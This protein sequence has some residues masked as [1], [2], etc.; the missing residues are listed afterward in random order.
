MTFRS[1]Y[2]LEQRKLLDCPIV[3]RGLR[4]LGP[5]SSCAPEPASPSWPTGE[6]ARRGGLRKASPRGCP[7][8][9]GDFGDE[10]TY[11]R[12]AD[13]IK[14]QPDAGLLPRGAAV[15][16]RSGD[17]GPARRRAHRELAR[18]RREAVRSRH[19]VRARAG[20]R[21]APVHRR[22]A[23]VPDRPL[24]R[25][26]GPHRA[27]VP[28]LL[29]HDARAGVEPEPH[30]VG[31]DHDGRDRRLRGPRQLL[32]AGR[33]PARRRRQP[34][35]ADGR[36]DRDGGA[37]A[38]RPQDDQGRDGARRSTPS[39][40]RARPHYV[41]GQ[42]D[43]YRSIK[44]VSPDSTTETFAALRL[45]IDNW[46]WAGVPF[47]I[48]TGKKMPVR[49][50]ELRLVFKQPPNLRLRVRLPPTRAQPARGPRRPAHRVSGCA[51]TR[52]APTRPAS[53]RSC[54]T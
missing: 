29:Q 26:D 31:A 12:V 10:A 49:Q 11:A 28:A 4:G 41:R 24:P 33:R 8:C 42:Y 44:G 27:A 1:L 54:S 20:R 3:G 21:A 25:E 6:T 17:P 35:H 46:R 36:R 16:L 7:T 13:A 14:G 47:F 19:R 50:T 37:L 22:G 9:H 15:P 45:Y 38:G 23:A 40:R 51:W 2:R 18:G 53:R 32:R 5:S 34:P 39:R 43:G 30:R 48:R 52:S